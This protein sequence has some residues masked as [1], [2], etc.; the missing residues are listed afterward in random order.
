MFKNNTTAKKPSQ[1]LKKL[2]WAFAQIQHSWTHAAW[3][4]YVADV[5][6]FF[7]LQLLPF[8]LPIADTLGADFWIQS[9]TDSTNM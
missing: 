5:L 2:N 7:C 8:S 9:F 6:I 1:C 4:T 3:A